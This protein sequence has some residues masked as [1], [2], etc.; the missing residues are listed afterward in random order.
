MFVCVSILALTE[1][2][3]RKSKIVYQHVILSKR[4]NKPG[5]KY[6]RETQ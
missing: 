4:K 6:Y 1:I 5:L 2:V 3:N